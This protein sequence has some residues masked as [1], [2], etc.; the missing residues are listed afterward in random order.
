MWKRFDAL[1]KQQPSSKVRTF[2]KSEEDVVARQATPIAKQKMSRGQ[3]SGRGLR[4]GVLGIPGRRHET[5]AAAAGGVCCVPALT[6]A[7]PC[8]AGGT[9]ASA[10]R[11]PP[12]QDGDRPAASAAHGSP[13]RSH[14]ERVYAPAHL[15]QGRPGGRGVSPP[16]SRG[17][18]LPS[19]QGEGWP[20]ATGRRGGPSRG[21]VPRSAAEA[22]G[23]RS[24]SGLWLRFVL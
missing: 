14:H 18:P 5:R 10:H 6:S 11:L 3:R 2:R 17:C 4:A 16:R 23:C 24:G 7:S 13:R 15:R 19:Y 8:V 22:A 12:G 21:P 9:D 20:R 1:R